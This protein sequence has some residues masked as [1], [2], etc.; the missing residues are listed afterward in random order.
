MEELS[1]SARGNVEKIIFRAFSIAVAI[2]SIEVIGNAFFQSSFLLPAH[3][4]L[5]ALIIFTQLGLLYGAWLSSKTRPWMILHG[6]GPVIVILAWPF[7][8]TQGVTLP[9]DF[10]PWVWW[11]MGMS[12]IS[13]SVAF[14]PPLSLIGGSLIALLWFLFSAEVYGGQIAFDRRV[15]DSVLV[16]MLGGVFGSLAG[17]I[18]EQFGKVDQANTNSLRESVARAQRD[19][20]ERERGLVDALVHDRVLNTLL[21]ASKAKQTGDYQ[22]AAQS[23]EQ[24]LQELSRVTED[25]QVK[26]AFSSLALFRALKAAAGELEGVVV[27]SAGNGSVVVPAEV[28]EALTQAALQALENSRKH[29]GSPRT[30]LHTEVSGR[31]IKI[32]IKDYGRGFRL[33]RISRNRLG[34]RL[35]IIG[36]VEAVGGVA[37]IASSPGIGT[38]VSLSWT[39][40]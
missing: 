14:R 36:R 6:I 20:I 38:E 26:S 22:S 15:Q 23:A 37:K 2:T 33:S 8:A 5:V 19:A 13:L 11:A 35:S 31:Q 7:L 9:E 18:I 21:L 29:S 17:L 3:W 16:L 4:L 40:Y 25:K 12:A 28:A 32:T 10:R 24:A 1:Y 34:L 27:S 39:R 30:Y